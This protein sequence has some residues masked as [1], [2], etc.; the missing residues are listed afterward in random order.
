MRQLGELIDRLRRLFEHAWSMYT[1]DL[2]TG[3]AKS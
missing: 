2:F 1:I 3:L